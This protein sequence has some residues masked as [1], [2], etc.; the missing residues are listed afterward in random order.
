MDELVSVERSTDRADA[1]VHHVRGRYHVD[2]GR[3]ADKRLLLQNRDGFIVEYVTTAV[4]HAV[5]AVRRVWVE[6]GVGDDAEG[7]K[8]LFQRRYRARHQSLGVGR[9]TPVGGFQ[10]LGDK[11]EYR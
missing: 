10:F 3:S 1:P 7:G 2:A 5:L 4:D 6:R 11:R 8:T 9:F